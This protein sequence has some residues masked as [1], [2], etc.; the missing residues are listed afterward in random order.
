MPKP[1]ALN[2]N[3]HEKQAKELLDGWGK[4]EGKQRSRYPLLAAYDTALSARTCSISWTPRS[5]LHNRTCRAVWRGF[6][7]W[8][9][10]LP[11]TILKQLTGA[12]AKAE[13]RA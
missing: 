5:H 12:A 3:L 10:A 6:E 4:A 1:F 9:A 8:L 2:L 11:P 7:Q 13:V